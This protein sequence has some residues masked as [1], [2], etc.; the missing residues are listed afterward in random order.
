[1]SKYTSLPIHKNDRRR[2]YLVQA[3]PKFTGLSAGEIIRQ[4]IE[5]FLQQHGI[6]DPY[7]EESTKEE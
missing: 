2:L 5:F 1:M 7:A 4:V 3:H 6:E